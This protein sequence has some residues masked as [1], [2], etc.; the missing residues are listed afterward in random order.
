MADHHPHHRL[1]GLQHMGRSLL[2]AS[3]LAASHPIP[4]RHYIIQ[5]R[6]LALTSLHLHPLCSLIASS[7]TMLRHAGVGQ[8]HKE[9]CMLCA[10]ARCANHA[11]QGVNL[12]FL[13]PSQTCSHRGHVQTCKSRHSHSSQSLYSLCRCLA[14]NQIARWTS[15]AD[16]L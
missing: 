14:D 15:D 2:S 13:T 11:P 1:L 3:W 4:V 5:K 16:L 7:G 8:N 12:P 9:P 10:H 6:S